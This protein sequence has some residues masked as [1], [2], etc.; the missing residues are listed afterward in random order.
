MG[1]DKNYLASGQLTQTTFIAF[2][3]Y[4]ILISWMIPLSLYVTLE[5]AKLFQGRFI[6]NDMKMYDEK[7]DVKCQV[8][9][10]SLNEDLG[11]VRFIFTDKTGTLTQNEM[12]FFKCSI[13]GV[14]YGTGVTE[15]SKTLALRKGKVLVEDAD[16]KDFYDDRIS[17][18]A[19]KKE[20][21][22]QEIEE[23]FKLLA[24]CHTVI[25]EENKETGKTTLSASSPDEEAI[26]NGIKLLGIEFISRDLKK[27]KIKVND[28]EEE[29]EILDTL[30][31]TSDR[32]RMSVILKN[33]DGKIFLYIKGAD[34]VIFSLAKSN[35][36][37]ERLT[38]EHLEQ[39][40]EE[41][42]RTL[43][44][45]KVEISEKDYEEFHIAYMEAK[46]LLDPN[47]K[48]KK[49]A[50]LCET[51]EKDI[52]V[53]GATALEDKLQDGVPFCLKE[54]KKAGIR[55]WMLTGD[56]LDTA[57]NIG[58]ACN[59]INDEMEIFKLQDSLYNTKE[60]IFQALKEFRERKTE[61]K[62]LLIEGKVSLATVLSDDELKED[63]VEFAL[64][65]QS[66]ICCR[67]SPKQKG[68]VVALVQGNIGKDEI[69]LAIGDGG[70][71]VSMLQVARI[72]IGI[73]GREGN[74]AANAADYSFGQFRFLK[75]LLFVHGRWCYRRGSRIVLY[76]F[77]K[78]TLLNIGSLFYIFY[79]GFSG[80]SVHDRWTQSFWNLIFTA[81]PI[82]IIG[83][84]D[85]DIDEDRA[86]DFPHLYKQGHE[87][88][89][90]TFPIFLVYFFNSFF[91]SCCIV[92]IQ[93]YSFEHL[94]LGYDLDIITFGVG[95]YTT[96]LVV[97]VLKALLETGSFTIINLLAAIFSLG[98]WFSFIFVYG[99]LYYIIIDPNWRDVLDVYRI[100][101]LPVYWIT[102]IATLGVTLMRDFTWKAYR[103]M[104]S[105]ELY[106]S[107][108]SSGKNIDRE[109]IKDGFP[110]EEGMPIFKESK[111]Q[112]QVKKLV[113]KSKKQIV[114]YLGFAF[115]QSEESL[116]N[117]EKSINHS[118]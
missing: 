74:Q 99:S 60:K 8:K 64:E 53:L 90:L 54:F 118:K 100:F 30:E 26:L 21:N 103:R 46:K 43:V 98:T 7:Y 19:W 59:I 29:Y 61:K 34:S 84:F 4:Y 62:A 117:L 76:S 17:N 111:A 72:G 67:V 44:V 36:D 52:E 6:S 22:S 80:A 91:H 101:Y 94:S 66:I 58:F 69:T 45:G 113:K 73:S 5:G 11:Q 18:G 48:Q 87:N 41:G 37:L 77:Y 1:Y 55:V 39:F 95:I 112:K 79:C 97:S 47:E 56:K 10:S 106:Y 20:K 102:L 88:R 27:M 14:T 70:N 32:K 89:Y 42:L 65:C 107:A 2:F 49:I 25:V 92:L 3:T 24:L 108:L 85:R 68:D 12:K 15:I 35:P 110:I 75:R 83:I 23:F 13:G 109:V 71:D 93:M 51:V 114:P 9:N 96:T 63:F 31:F 38:N 82:A 81:W 115:S 28:K 16:H 86:E 78:N 40:G 57:Q 116:E 104:V 50:K 105:Q 33:S